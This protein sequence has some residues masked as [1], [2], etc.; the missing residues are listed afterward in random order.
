MNLKSLYF[1]IIFLIFSFVLKSQDKLLNLK[2]VKITLKNNV[3][4]IVN[5]PSS[6]GIVATGNGGIVSEGDLNKV[7]WKINN[8]TGTYTIPFW[9]TSRIDL[10]YQITTAG[11]SP[12]ALIA[13]TRGTGADNTPLPTV[14][15]AVEDLNI[16]GANGSY[17]VVDRYWILRKEGWSTNPGATLSFKYQDNEIAS[18]NTISEANLSAQ[19]WGQDPYAPPG[20]YSWVPDAFDV[21][22]GFSTALGTAE[23][24][25]NRVTNVVPPAGYQGGFYTWILVDKA[26][27]LPV[28]LLYF[29]VYC[30]GKYV[31]LKWE[32]ASEINCDY[33]LVE[34]SSDGISWE[35][36]AYIQGAGNSNEVFTYSWA[37]NYDSKGTALYYRLT[38]FDYDGEYQVLGIQS[39]L[40]NA[41]ADDSWITINTDIFNNILINFTATEGEPYEIKVF[42]LLGELMYFQSGNVANSIEQFVISTYGW[43]SSIYLVDVRSS[44]VNKT[45]KVYIQEMDY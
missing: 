6:N 3:A 21:F 8:N 30:V 24:A 39:I 41:A 44:L 20:T 38:Q 37:D 11:S 16:N 23:P 12:G 29:K 10:V 40:C 7:V 4:L 33:Y 22:Q 35:P 19:L 45:Q 34:R 31:A 36:V 27:P 17:Y 9:K 26:H 18:P 13:S 14:A 5:Q 25:N 2:D 28:T 42:N 43:T 32:T 15:P 1:I